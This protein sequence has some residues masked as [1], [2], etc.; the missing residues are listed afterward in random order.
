M[1]AARLKLFTEYWE[2]IRPSCQTMKYAVTTRSR[3][4]KLRLSQ[5]TTAISN[6]AVFI[7]II[8]IGGGGE[9][10]SQYWGSS[11]ITETGGTSRGH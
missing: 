2:N 10:Q 4:R 6:T 7:I 1:L 3:V 11:L 9:L 5:Q 8:I